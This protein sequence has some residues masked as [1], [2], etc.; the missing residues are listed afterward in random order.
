[1]ILGADPVT[2]PPA[3]SG[4]PQGW[5]V[6]ISV[7]SVAVTL[8]LG[9]LAFLNTRRTATGTN[10]V[11]SAQASSIARKDLVEE[12]VR[13]NLQNDILNAQVA[14]LQAQM[15][16]LTR[17]QVSMRSDLDRERAWSQTLAQTMR[18]A[19]IPVPERGTA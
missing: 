6:F 19:G 15:S 12:V 3:S 2:S 1:M 8:I 4:L 11:S 9:L 5:L 17:S 13:L 18:E 7:A 14:A 10:E 16:G